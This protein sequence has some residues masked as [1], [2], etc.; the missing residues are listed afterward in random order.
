MENGTRQQQNE[1]KKNNTGQRFRRGVIPVRAGMLKRCTRVDK[2][3][4]WRPV[5]HFQIFTGCDRV[6]IW[7]GHRLPKSEN[8]TTKSKWRKKPSSSYHFLFDFIELMKTGVFVFS[9]HVERRRRAHHFGTHTHKIRRPAMFAW[10]N[11]SYKSNCTAPKDTRERPEIKRNSSFTHWC[12]STRCTISWQIVSPYI[13]GFQQT[14][15]FPFRLLLW[16]CSARVQT[17]LTL[18]VTFVF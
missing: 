1:K 18:D 12:V 2:V 10:H 3:Y 13:S 9:L 6:G 8:C 14:N 16:G 7:P 4:W 5:W 11:E 15:L 17:L